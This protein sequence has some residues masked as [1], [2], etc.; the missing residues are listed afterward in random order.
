MIDTWNNSMDIIQD[1]SKF[2]ILKQVEKPI[3]VIYSSKEFSEFQSKAMTE[4]WQN[5]PEHSK[6]LGIRMKNSRIKINQA[7]ENGTFALQVL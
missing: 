6:N 7:I 3:D 4:F 5:Y 1:L 2:L